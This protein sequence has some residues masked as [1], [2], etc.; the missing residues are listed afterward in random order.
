MERHEQRRARRRRRT[1]AVVPTLFTLGNV[2]CG[3]FAIVVAA[4]VGVPDLSVV[5]PSDPTNIML[6]AWLIFLA[7]AFDA[8]DGQVARLSRTESDFGAQLDSLCDLVSF[9]VAP[10][11]LL[12]KMVPGF[13]YEHREIVWIIAAA[14]V[15]C[16]AL[17][18]ARFSVETGD[19]DD[20]TSF[21]GLPS[22]AAAA[23]IASFAIMF[24]SLRVKHNHF[25]WAREMDLVLQMALP[26]LALLVA[27]LMVSRIRYPHLM[28]RMLRG[29]H[30]FAHIVQL[31]FAL[32]LIALI[33]GYSV[34]L[35]CCC[36]ALGPPARYLWDD[37]V[38]GKPHE[39][40][41]F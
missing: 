22:P 41:L 1:I 30:N 34:P 25:V 19:E 21:H 33:R 37:F 12:V 10:G 18:L 17:R 6:S 28:S 24:H 32:V 4:R 8:L 40:P 7:M 36:F 31:V 23:V 11:F 39:E 2:I 38:L 15:A 9:G 35:V 16:A 5:E 14:F 20:H 13:T 26:C 29:H 3:F 27:L